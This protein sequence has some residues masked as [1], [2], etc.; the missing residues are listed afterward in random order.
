M[1]NGKFDALFGGP[2]RKPEELLTQRD[3]D[4][5]ASIQAVTEEVVLRLTRAL[6]RETGQREPLPGRRR[7]AQLR[8]QRQA[9]ARRHVR[10]TSGSSR[11]PA[12]PAA[13]SARRC[14]AYHLLHGPAAHGSTA[15][16]TAC[17]ARYLGP[18]LRRRRDR[19]SAS[20]RPARASTRARRRRADRAHRATRWPTGKA[21]GWFQGRMEFG[22]R[23]LGARSIL[24][25]PRSPDD[26]EDAQPQDQVPRERSARSRRRCCARTSADWFELDGDSPYML[27]VRRRARGAPPRR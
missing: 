4:L 24:G 6:A 9:P 15:S 11:R 17:T 5:A 22:P 12:M 25:D 27:L 26:A 16:S 8:R 7:G 21:V 23:A 20:R 18:G 14:A 10:A 13:R 2:P 3:M 1:T 19:A